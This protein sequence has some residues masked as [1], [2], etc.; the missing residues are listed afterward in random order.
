MSKFKAK[1]YT[2][3]KFGKRIRETLDT[4]SGTIYSKG[5]Y[6]TKLNEADVPEYYCPIHSRSIWYMK[7]WVLTKGVTDIAYTY[8]KEN[9]LFKDDY[10]YLCYD[11]K[12]ER[13]DLR[14]GGVDYK[15]GL[16]ISGGDILDII[17]YVEKYSPNV[18]TAGVRELI[19]EKVKYLHEH[20]TDYY[21][22]VFH[23][24]DLV[25][26]FEYYKKE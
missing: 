9:H 13:V 8:C 21:Y 10:I 20:E 2:L 11:G 18:D 15:N 24:H 22:D 23:T 6:K 26:V 1:Y 12:L 5:Q 4:T 7:G 3:G 17:L 14:W 25:D 19:A 16:A